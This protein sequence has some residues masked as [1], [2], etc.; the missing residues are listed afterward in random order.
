MHRGARLNLTAPCQ[1]PRDW[2]GQHQRIKGP[3]GEMRQLRKNRGLFCGG[4]RRA[5]PQAQNKPPDHQKQHQNPRNGVAR[6]SQGLRVNAC[7]KRLLI[8]LFNAF[9]VDELI[10]D[11]GGYAPM[12]RNLRAAIDQCF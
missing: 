10:N 12:Q 7:F 5:A 9:V 6:P 1:H 3:M 8:G 2:Q 4:I 11:E